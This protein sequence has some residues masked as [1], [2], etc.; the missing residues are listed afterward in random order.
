VRITLVPS[1]TAGNG[2]PLQFLTSVLLNDT[3]ALDA[4]CLGMDAGLAEQERVK[5]V[6]LSHTHIDHLASL[7]VFLNTVFTGDE[8]CVTVYG[9]EPVL[10]CLRCQGG[11]VLGS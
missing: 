9:T 8:D 2:G 6:F 7:P 4:G 3:V 5:H 10:N 1:S 11:S